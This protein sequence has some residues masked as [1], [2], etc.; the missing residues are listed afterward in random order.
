MSINLIDDDIY[1]NHIDISNTNKWREP[2]FKTQL[3]IVNYN[4]G[5][6][7]AFWLKSLLSFNNIKFW[8]KIQSYLASNQLTLINEW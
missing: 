7:N 3:S 6:W 2:W 1:D 4:E 8:F 5:Y